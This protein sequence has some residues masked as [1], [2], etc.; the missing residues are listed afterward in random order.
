MF[1]KNN[2]LYIRY[3]E[4][5]SQQLEPADFS[6]T[7]DV[8]T[9]EQTSKRVFTSLVTKT[10]LSEIGFPFLDYHFE[11]LLQNAK[12]FALY[13]SS[14]E[15]HQPAWLKARALSD[16][17]TFLSARKLASVPYR[18]RVLL[19]KTSSGIHFEPSPL[20]WPFGAE[21]SAIGVSQTRFFPEVKSN[22][23]NPCIAA[24]KYAN[25]QGCDEG[26][27]IDKQGYL[28]EGAWSNVFWFT[29]NKLYTTKSQVLGGVT[30]RIIIE[31][32]A[33]REIDIT[34]E[35]FLH[36]AQ[37]VCISQS[38]TGI[39]PVVKINGNPIGS[40]STG[41]RVKELIQ[42][43]ERLASAQFTPIKLTPINNLS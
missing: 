21:I 7:G 38:S 22:F 8:S 29:S 18:L 24:R 43:Y 10:K 41:P 33:V 3:S 5:G 28:R 37:E 40:G 2:S 42:L 36:E 14:L 16:I 19:D 17:A 25:E 34:F 9:D 27:L 6:L 11:R 39:T 23:V 26:L 1:E 32:A 35:D 4:T 12:E 13:Q 31:N 15:C 20:P 30:R